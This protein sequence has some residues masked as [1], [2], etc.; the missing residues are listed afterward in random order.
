MQM[1]GICCCK[2]IG[3]YQLDPFRVLNMTEK[4]YYDIRVKSEDGSKDYLI[5]LHVHE[6]LAD[7]YIARESMNTLYKGMTVYKQ[8]SR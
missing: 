8:R 4:V 5:M 6:D 3:S 7:V 1:Y 2:T